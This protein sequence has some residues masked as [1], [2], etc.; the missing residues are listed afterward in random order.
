MRSCFDRDQPNRASTRDRAD[1]EIRL[2]ELAPGVILGLS[3]AVRSGW[4]DFEG[5]VSGGA[6]AKNRRARR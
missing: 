2:D 6:E 4:T 1:H 5:T 3:Y